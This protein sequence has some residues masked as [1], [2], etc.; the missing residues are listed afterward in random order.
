MI[1]SDP[2]GNRLFFIGGPGNL[3][4]S[5]IDELLK[6]SYQIAVYST[7]QS[8]AELDPVIKSYLG[9]RNNTPRLQEALEDFKPDIVL[10][11]ALFT[12]VQAERLLP[13]VDGKIRQ[14]I[15]ISTV[16]VYGYPLSRLPFRED[17]LWY[18]TTQSF[19]AENKRQCE[20]FLHS[21]YHPARFPLT[22]V[23]P[24]YSFGSRFL[25]SFMS[26]DQGYAMLRRLKTGRPV[27]VPGDGT[28][29][30]HVSAAANTGKM[31]ATLVDS[32]R[33]IGKDYTCGHPIFTTHAGYVRLLAHVLGVEPN[34]VNIPT[35]VITSV[36]HPDARSSLLH[37]LTRFN[38]A[39]S[40]DRFL[41]DF[42]EF[43]WK[44]SL[45]NWARQVVESISQQGFLDGPDA[46]IFDDRIIQAWLKHT[47]EILKL[48]DLTP[49]TSP[50]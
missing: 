45:D 23:R 30:M 22:I 37:S 17:D 25:I 6:R 7:G 9:D 49:K 8:F 38:V 40:I 13:L 21:R 28:T 29:L 11:F 34:M 16:D 47:P 48:N 35:E 39:F 41:R 14:F 31:I 3:S 4:A 42:P 32:S 20:A 24:A 27:L 44:V 18:P 1:M 26:R 12:P 46:E 33:A 50:G 5:A 36:N 19:Y 43:Q 15:F 10:D 2:T